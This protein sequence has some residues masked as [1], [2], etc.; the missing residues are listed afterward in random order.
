MRSWIKRGAI[1]ALAAA[2]VFPVNVA[3]VAAHD[4]GGGFG[5]GV[6]AGILGLGVL[7]A[8]ES[9]RDRDYYEGRYGPY[10]R[11]GPLECHTYE[12]RC[13]RD[14]YGERVCP[15]AERRCFRREICD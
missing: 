6:A 9:E 8:I 11:P 13:Y 2:V 3:P 14:E 12:A 15:P 5:A 1:V 7:G 4:H 10:C